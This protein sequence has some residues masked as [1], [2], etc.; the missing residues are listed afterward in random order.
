MQETPQKNSD[1]M[2]IPFVDLKAQYESIKG[3]IDAA[4]ATVLE[5]TS[6]IGG[7]NVSDFK[8]NFENFY[9][10]D[11]CVPCANGT[12]ALYIAMK[13]MGIGIGD[14]VITTASSWISTSETISQTGARPV[15]IDIDK[16]YTI[17]PTKIEAK[18]TSKTKAIIPVHLYGQMCDMPAIMA[19]AKRHNLKVIEDCAQSHLSSLDQKMAGLWGDA[20]TFSFYPGKNLGAYGDAGCLITNSEKLAI[21]CKRYANHGALVKHEHEI[22]GINSRLDG[23]QAAV[24]NVKIPHLKKW[25]AE[26]ERVGNSYL[27]LLS[28]LAEIQLP[29]L[30]PN[31]SHSFHVFGIKVN[32]RTKLQEFLKEKGVPT[33]I[34]YPRAMPFMKAYEHQGATIADFPNSFDLQEKELSLPIFPEMTNEQITKVCD[35]IK[36]YFNV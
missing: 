19:I 27:E 26:R 31:S 30:R 16:Y 7:K 29:L 14:E 17:D 36:E 1:K 24:L 8:A 6:F 9:G 11:Y 3:E 28:D 2:N 23:L 18:I 33:Q 13:M 12:D 10:V 32:E 35:S 20:G 34:H 22:E 25:T 4:I 21:D 5:N 15:F